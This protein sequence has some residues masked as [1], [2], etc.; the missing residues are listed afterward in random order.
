[1]NRPPAPGVPAPDG[2]PW[3]AFGYLVAGVGFYGF[4]GWGLSVWL[5]ADYW[6]PIGILV[7]LGFGMYLVFSRYRI[8]GPNAPTDSST[9]DDAARAQRPDDNDRGETA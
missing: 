4:L 8:G 1:M 3:A 5:H 9:T 7:G 6:I 2:D